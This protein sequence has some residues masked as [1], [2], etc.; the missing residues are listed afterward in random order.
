MYFEWFTRKF[1]LYNEITNMS[2]QWIAIFS[3]ILDALLM[4]SLGQLSKYCPL[5]PH[6]P[7][8]TAQTIP[9]LGQRSCLD[10]NPSRTGDFSHT[11]P[12]TVHQILHT[13]CQCSMWQPLWVLYNQSSNSPIIH[14]ISIVWQSNVKLPSESHSALT[15]SISDC[16]YSNPKLRWL[17]FCDRLTECLNNSL[18][19]S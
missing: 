10:S 12:Q 11:D 16:D 5:W 7:G 19:T 18:I 3:R 6:S 1:D 9:K 8:S 14:Y 17:T 4:G 13:P 15:Y 2:Y